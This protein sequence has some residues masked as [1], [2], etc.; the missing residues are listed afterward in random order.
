MHCNVPFLLGSY[1]ILDQRDVEAR[2]RLTYQYTLSAM[3][4]EG[5]VLPSES[6]KNWQHVHV[7]VMPCTGCFAI[8]DCS[9]KCSERDILPENKSYRHFGG[10]S[11]STW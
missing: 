6:A 5:H 10:A 7:F 8:V 1:S 3:A 4:R 2:L 11:A 9:D